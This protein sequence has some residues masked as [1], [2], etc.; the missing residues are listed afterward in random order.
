MTDGEKEPHFNDS[1]LDRINSDDPIVVA[2][3][4]YDESQSNFFV[5]TSELVKRPVK[6]KYMAAQETLDIM[7]ESFGD[8]VEVAYTTEDMTTRER[9]ETTTTLLIGADSERVDHFKKINPT[10]TYIYNNMEHK[11][12]VNNWLGC[13]EDEELDLPD[14]GEL[15]MDLYSSNLSADMRELQEQLQSSPAA[16]RIALKNLFIQHTLDV[17][18]TSAGLIIAG[19]VTH[20]IIKRNSN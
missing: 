11:E 10:G 20:A 12:L 19:L 15:N 17:G 14:L 6:N 2:T 13:I 7:R 9:I 5:A 8:F 16:R 4:L 18:K 3:R 1:S